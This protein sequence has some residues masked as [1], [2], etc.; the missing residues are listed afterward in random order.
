MPGPADLRTE[1][2]AASRANDEAQNIKQRVQEE[3]HRLHREMRRARA[4]VE[5]NVQS[6]RFLK[7]TTSY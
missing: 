6:A 5:L 7:Y 3:M 4:E 2:T 1:R